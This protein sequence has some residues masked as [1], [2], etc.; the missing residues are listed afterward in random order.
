[1]SPNPTPKTYAVVERIREPQRDALRA[2]VLRGLARAYMPP[3][4]MPV[5]EW[6]DT[7]RFFSPEAAALP[8]KWKT[9]KEPMA[10]GVMDALATPWWK[11]SPP[12]APL[13]F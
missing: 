1:M 7:Y 4:K 6:A 3:P 5:S 13:R 9:S 11:R 10:K 12:C 8:G 2:A